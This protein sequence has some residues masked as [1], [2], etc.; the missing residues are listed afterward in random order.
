MTNQARSSRTWSLPV[1]AHGPGQECRPT[2]NG[3]KAIFISWLG[4]SHLLGSHSSEQS[5]VSLS[6]TMGYELPWGLS[7][8][9]PLPSHWDQPQSWP[10]EWHRL[11][12]HQLQ[13]TI[14]WL[15]VNTMFQ[16][17]IVHKLFLVSRA[18]WC[19]MQLFSQLRLDT[20]ILCQFDQCKAD[21]I[22]S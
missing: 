15:P 4:F 12:L 9:T 17:S 6:L 3:M 5:N 14:S 8:A 22:S 2:L 18:C 21:S 20:F 10:A 13:V 16:E 11:N 1:T 19:T 7:L